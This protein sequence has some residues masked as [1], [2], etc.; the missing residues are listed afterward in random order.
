MKTVR[1]SILFLLSIF[2][3]SNLSAMS[4][5][6]RKVQN[7]SMRSFNSGPDRYDNSSDLSATS[8]ATMISSYRQYG[9]NSLDL[10][11]VELTKDRLFLELCYLENR[12]ECSTNNVVS[13]LRFYRSEFGSR[14]VELLVNIL[15]NNIGCTLSFS[16]CHI[17]DIAAENLYSILKVSGFNLDMDLYGIDSDDEDEVND[18]VNDFIEDLNSEHTIEFKI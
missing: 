14:E 17:D 15:V 8:R 16:S 9:I 3:F 13:S 2:L 6:R 18:F 4:S 5:F 12:L 1:N 11:F 7:R 10:K